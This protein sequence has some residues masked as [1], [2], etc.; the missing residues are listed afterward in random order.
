MRCT[1]SPAATWSRS[2]ATGSWLVHT[3]LAGKPH[4]FTMVFEAAGSVQVHHAGACYQVDKEEMLGYME[5]CLD[6]NFMVFL[7]VN[8][9][10]A[11]TEGLPPLLD[12]QA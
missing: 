5:K 4:C 7:K 8:E 3:F 12:L 6:K 11:H 9:R 10:R 1:L 2:E